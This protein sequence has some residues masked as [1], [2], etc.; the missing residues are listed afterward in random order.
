MEIEKMGR[1]ANETQAVINVVNE[2]SALQ[3]R[4]VITSVR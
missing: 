4:S 1:H 3:C 2:L